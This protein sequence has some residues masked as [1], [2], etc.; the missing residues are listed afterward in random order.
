MNM[1]LLHIFQV[2]VPAII[3]GAGVYYDVQRLKKELRA[4]FKNINSE[5]QL[6][7]IS[8]NKIN[9]DLKEN[10]V[11]DVYRDKDIKRLESEIQGIKRKLNGL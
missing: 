10:K 9:L 1:E 7:N 5:L 2:V 8:I 6:I 3:V 11:G 4:G